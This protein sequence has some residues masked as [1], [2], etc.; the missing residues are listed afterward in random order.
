LGARYGYGSFI[1]AADGRVHIGIEKVPLVVKPR[2]KSTWLEQKMPLL[3]RR[4][5]G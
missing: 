5:G 1:G 3:R 2:A 4:T